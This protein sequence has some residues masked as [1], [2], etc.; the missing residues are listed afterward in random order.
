[1][2]GE[3]IIAKLKKLTPIEGADRIQQADI[4]GETVIIPIIHKEGERGLLFDCETQLSHEFVYYNNLY[5]KEKMNHDTEKSGYIEEKRR[6]RPIKLRGVKCSGLWMP[7]SSL[8]NIPN[9]KDFDIEQLK[10]G[11]QFKSLGGIN[12][13]DKYISPKTRRGMKS[14]K[15]GELKTNKAP[16]FK[17]HVDTDQLMR[18]TNELFEKELVVVTEKLHG[19][20]GRVGYLPVLQDITWSEK[21]FSWIFMGNS[22][23]IKTN[24]NFVVGSRRVVKSIDGDDVGNKEHFYNK[25][26]WT[27]IGTEFFKDKLNKGETVYFEIVGFT[28]DGEYIMPP[29]SNEKLKNFL[30]KNEYKDFIKKYGNTTEFTYNCINE[31]NGTTNYDVYVY[32]IT[33]TNEDGVSYDLSWDQVKLRSEELGVKHVPELDKRILTQREIDDDLFINNVERLSGAASTNF[34]THLREGVVVRIENG[35][36]TPVFLK[37]KSFTFKVLEGIIKESDILDVEESN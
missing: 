30:E 7:L 31:P 4:F 13:C 34:K 12:I 25:D 5:R 8:K 3:F 1:M 20:S 6:V 35:K 26:L 2:T 37:H 15:I 17:K 33:I 19:T 32:R 28:P 14:N 18:N 11:Q 16:T 24:Y 36:K 29:V 22:N 23:P 21:L 10:D 9:L 27:K